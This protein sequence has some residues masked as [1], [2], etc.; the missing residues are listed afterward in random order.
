VVPHEQE[1]LIV[2]ASEGNYLRILNHKFEERFYEDM[3]K[4]DMT[5]EGSKRV[6]EGKAEKLDRNCSI[7]SLSQIEAK[8]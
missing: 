2:L 6:W 3:S 1:L 5:E 7:Q 8:G 4:L